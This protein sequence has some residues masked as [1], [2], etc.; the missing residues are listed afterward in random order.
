MLFFF[1][2]TATTEIYTLTLH[3][4]LPISYGAGILPL[5][6]AGNWRTDADLAEVYT[7]WGGVAYGRD[8]DGV[9]AREDMETNYRRIAADWKS[10]RLNP[11]HANIGCPLPLEKKKIPL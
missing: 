11:S 9:S 3:D 1:N 2:D 8:L 6:E 7:A 4:A 5:M 10:T